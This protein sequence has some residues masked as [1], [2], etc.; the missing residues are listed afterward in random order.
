MLSLNRLANLL[1]NIGLW[2]RLALTITLGFAIFFTIFSLLSIRTVN[3]STNRILDERLVLTQMAADDINALLV[4]AFYELEK[5]TTFARFNPQADNLEEEYHMLAHAYGRV[6]SFSLGIYFYDVTGKVILAEPFDAGMIGADHSTNPHIRQVIE[7]GQ[8]SVSTPF[9]E[10]GAGTPA[11]ALTIPIRDEQGQFISML[12]GLIDLSSPSIRR[13]IEQ[14]LKL[15][16]TGHA[17][18][19]DSQGNVVVSTYPGV[20]L[21]TGEHV[22]FYRRM[23]A[24][25]MVGVETVPY[26]HANGATEAMHVMAFAPLS[27]ADW[28]V[29]IGGD[30][31]ET[32]APVVTLRNS[33]LL[34][35]G[36][37]L[38]AVLTATLIGTRRLV[39]PVNVLTGSAQRIAEGDLA[40]PIQLSEGGEIGLLGRSLEEMRLKLKE[41]IDEIQ[42]WNVELEDRV[43][44]RT[45]ELEQLM[46]EISKFHAI[47]EL[48]R[49]KSEFISTISHELRTPLGFI[50]GYVTTLLRSDVPHSEET[51]QDFLQIIKEESEKLEELVE[52]L[53]DTSRIQAGSFA[54]KKEPTDIVKLTQKVIEKVQAITDQHSFSLRFDSSLPLVPGDSRRLEQ[55]LHNLLDNAIKYSVSDSQITINGEMK[56]GHI[57]VSVADES[58]GIPQVE[59]TKIFDA[60]YRLPDLDDQKVRGIGLGLTICRA[61]VE[62]HGGS[63]WA[64]SA[65]GQ[66]TVFCFTLPLQEDV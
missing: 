11:V 45:K 2:P 3:D 5:A 52:N 32:F 17:E 65:Q 4:Q 47:R 10:P 46:E 14:A 35:G 40:S 51:R 41:S 28:G 54:V 27:I 1:H 61:I 16:H 59:L 30:A 53:L 49:L 23:M 48:D 8:K 38:V 66:G 22:T 50:T 39:R 56:N 21:Q 55:V 43:N 36:L 44:E 58:P 29:S 6:G 34:I 19:V 15:G 9:V 64:E 18:I 26:E 63:I 60:F 33:I 42:R 20:F 57:Q 62:A 31:T 37:M 12:S 13:P 25:E 7:S 24:Q